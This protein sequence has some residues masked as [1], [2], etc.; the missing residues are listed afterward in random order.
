MGRDLDKSNQE[1]I[2]FITLD[3]ERAQ[4]GNPLILLAKD[5]EDQKQLSQDIAKT[6]KAYDEICFTNLEGR[7]PRNGNEIAGKNRYTPSD[8][9]AVFTHI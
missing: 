2:A 4:N 3:K 5:I 6:L 8:G 7:N 9:I 1:I